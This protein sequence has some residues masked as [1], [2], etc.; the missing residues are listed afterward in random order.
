[1]ILCTNCFGRH[2]FLYGTGVLPVSKKNTCLET[3][4]Y[5]WCTPGVPL[6]YPCRAHDVKLSII[7]IRSNF[8]RSATESNSLQRSK[9]QHN[10]TATTN[11]SQQQVEYELLPDT[12]HVNR[13]QEKVVFINRS[14]KIPK[15]TIIAHKP[16]HAEGTTTT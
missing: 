4:A 15:T 10:T 6:A 9:S 7:G 14:T 16:M 2:I 11:D 12:N 8:G 1:M 13:G 5:P 3:V